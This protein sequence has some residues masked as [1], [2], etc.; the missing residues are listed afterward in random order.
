MSV[1]EIVLIVL[2]AG[3]LCAATWIGI[4]T[5]PR[6]R[7][8]LER[9]RQYQD[10]GG[11][12]D[13]EVRLEMSLWERFVNPWLEGL[14]ARLQFSSKQSLM[15]QLE[16]QLEL[17]GS[18]AGLN[19]GGL[20]A[21]QFLAIF[22]GAGFGFLLGNFVLAV[23]T[24]PLIALMI[25]MAA[26]GFYVPRIWLKR[27]I[28]ARRLEIV[29]AMPN[30]LDLLTLS[31][32][33]GLAFDGALLRVAEKYQNALAEEFSLVLAEMKLGRTR[34]DALTAMADRLGIEDMTGFVTAIVQSSELG[35]NLGETLRIQSVDMR[36]R[37][38]QRAEEKGN[39][40]PLKM[41]I[42]M[43]GCIFPSLFVV[44]LG[45]AAIQLIHQFSQH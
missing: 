12:I 32:E 31:V 36:R 1:L 38:R 29:E 16:T 17:A 35:T 42:P 15:A 28:S 33:A 7:E 45:P 40:A 14:G 39:Q 20:I 44:L 21:M 22:A 13:P 19:P 30:A 2:V 41:L 11:Y 34:K 24:G 26:L 10:L 18:P 43:V 25:A 9:L 27:A 8:L 4:A 37:R 5:R 6:R 23:D 3:S